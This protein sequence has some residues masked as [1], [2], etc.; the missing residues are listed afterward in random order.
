MG[1]SSFCESLR[2]KKEEVTRKSFY[3]LCAVSEGYIVLSAEDTAK[4]HERE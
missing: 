2:R 3:A 4:S 1:Q